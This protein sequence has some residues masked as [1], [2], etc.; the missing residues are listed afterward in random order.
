MKQIIIN[1]DM[2][3]FMPTLSGGALMPP[4]PQM[5]PIEGTG[6]TKIGGEP[7]CIEGD[8]KSVEL[9]GMNYMAPGFPIPGNGTFKI[10]KLGGDQLTKKSKCDK[11]AIIVKGTVFTAA[12]KVDSPA[13]QLPNM[14][15]APDPLKQY[16][17]QGMLM[18]TN[19][20]VTGA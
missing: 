14:G 4:V 18:A 8:E 16:T 11:K 1:G 15:G 12:F 9:K 7:I 10:Q 5:T 19:M 3:Q 13:K 20:T 6:T 17:G 2:V